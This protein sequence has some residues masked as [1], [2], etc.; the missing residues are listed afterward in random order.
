MEKERRVWRDRRDMIEE[1]EVWERE[2]AVVGKIKE[3]VGREERLGRE[4]R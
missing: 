2:R 1:R 3:R 4:E